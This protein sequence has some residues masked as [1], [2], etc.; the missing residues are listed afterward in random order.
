V[1][2]P[3]VEPL[4][5]PEHDAPSHTHSPLTQCWP[6]P[7]LPPSHTPPQPSSAPHVLPAH[8]G[9]HPQAPGWPPPL[10]VS[11][12][13]HVLPLAQQ[14]WPLPPHVPQSTPHV[15]PLAHAAQTTPPLP[16]DPSSTPLAH[17]VP[18]QQPEHDVTSHLQT[19]DTHRCPWPH[20]LSVQTP[21]QPLLSPQDLP[22]QLEVHGPV[23]QTFG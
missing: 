1:P 16:H 19:P 7:Q 18:L 20:A 2:A 6:P 17:V 15:S 3:H 11:G 21:S 4:Q 8:V 22:V 9:V 10:H 5:Q 13:A 23:P 14:G 12:V